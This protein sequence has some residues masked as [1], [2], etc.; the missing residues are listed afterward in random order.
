MSIVDTHGHHIGLRQPSPTPGKGMRWIP[1][2]KKDDPGHE[3]YRRP[4]TN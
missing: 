2:H 4:T 1:E 3:E